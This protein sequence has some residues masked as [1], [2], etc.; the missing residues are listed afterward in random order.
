VIDVGPSPFTRALEFEIPW[1]VTS[2]NVAAR[3]V[4]RRTI[5]NPAAVRDK[6]RIWGIAM[7]AK[8]EQ[9]WEMP[10]AA[11]L[12]VIAFNT[13]KDCDNCAKIISDSLHGVAWTD[14]RVIVAL[15]VEKRV[16]HDGERYLVRVEPRAALVRGKKPRKARVA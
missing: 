11:A 15:Y 3:R 7:A 12:S 16:D 9:R 13:R 8:V 1:R 14:D 2:N 4:G 6:E 5:P 10:E